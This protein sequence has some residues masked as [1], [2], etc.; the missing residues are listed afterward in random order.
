MTVRH[1]PPPASEAPFVP[2]PQQK[3][4]TRNRL[5]IHYASAAGIEQ[6]GIIVCCTW[7]VVHYLVALQQQR[8][9]ER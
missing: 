8:H 5:R 6:D 2:N 4:N 3:V 1:F 9:Q 7:G